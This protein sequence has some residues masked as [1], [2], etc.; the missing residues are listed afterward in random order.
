[1]SIKR[2]LA[3]PETLEAEVVPTKNS[4]GVETCVF[5]S[6]RCCAASPL[7]QFTAAIGSPTGT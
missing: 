4:I 6:F 2:L 3:R 1:M 7:H 5:L